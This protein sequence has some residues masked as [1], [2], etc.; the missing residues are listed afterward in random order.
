MI[1]QLS[2]N[3]MNNHNMRKTTVIHSIDHSQKIKDQKEITDFQ[4]DFAECASKAVA[5]GI[6]FRDFLIL[7][8]LYVMDMKGR[9]IDFAKKIGVKSTAITQGVNRLEKL[10]FIKRKTSKDDPRGVELSKTS[11][12]MI[13]FR[14]ITKKSLTPSGQGMT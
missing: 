12:G 5:L 4:N 11:K 10:R 3:D 9:V 1:N 7:Y 8:Y 14:K 6:P 2:E 13:F